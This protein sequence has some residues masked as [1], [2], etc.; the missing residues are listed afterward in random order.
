MIWFAFKPAENL[1]SACSVT[2]PRAPCVVTSVGT[3]TSTKSVTFPSPNDVNTKV[4]LGTVP[5]VLSAPAVFQPVNVPA[6]KVPVSPVKAAP[7]AVEAFATVW[8]VA[9]LLAPM[10]TLNPIKA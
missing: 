7:R 10:L 2:P 6:V 5:L 8:V 3:P 1:A 9:A 4:S